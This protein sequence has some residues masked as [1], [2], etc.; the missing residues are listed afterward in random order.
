[1]KTFIVLFV[2][3]FIVFSFLPNAPADKSNAKVSLLLNQVPGRSPMVF[4]SGWVF[5]A[6]GFLHNGNEVDII[7]AKD[8]KWSGSGTFTPSTGPETRPVFN[9]DGNNFIVM[10]FEY[11]GVTYSETFNVFT[12]NPELYAAVGDIA[13]CPADAHGC[14][15]CPHSVE[16]PI[17]QGSPTVKIG[18]APAARKGDN[19]I[20][21]DCCGANTFVINSGDPNVLIDGKPAARFNDDKTKHCGGFGKIEKG[22]RMT[23]S[24][25]EDFKVFF[26]E[27]KKKKEEHPIYDPNH[28]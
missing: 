9:S 6:T 22:K 25:I 3:L 16:G 2:S 17:L 24:E 19:G 14:L 26:K 12:V 20:H 7:N 10:T 28:E 1:M 11:E 23:A 15:A 4:T 21:M 18:D 8:V 27:R 5:G 13:Y